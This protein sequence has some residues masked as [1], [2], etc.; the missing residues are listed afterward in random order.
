M[1]QRYSKPIGSG[2]YS[3]RIS[4]QHTAQRTSPGHSCSVVNRSFSRNRSHLGN[5][6]TMG[7]SSLHLLLGLFVAT[8]L[9]TTG[10]ASEDNDGVSVASRHHA[11]CTYSREAP[12]LDWQHIE[13]NYR[14]LNRTSPSVLTGRPVTAATASQRKGGS[15]QDATRPS[16][17]EL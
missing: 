8:T 12:Q 6:T 5:S 9:L 1:I 16:R 7:S 13:H 17:P 15:G 11:S 3:C 4:V 10:A 2:Y 14:C